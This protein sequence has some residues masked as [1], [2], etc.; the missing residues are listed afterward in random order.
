MKL[1]VEN[2]VTVSKKKW[3][4]LDPLLVLTLQGYQ[5]AGLYHDLRSLCKKY[6]EEDILPEDVR[7]GDLWI[8]VKTDQV[9][10]GELAFSYAYP[11]DKVVW[12]IINNSLYQF[13]PDRHLSEEQKIAWYKQVEAGTDANNIGS[14]PSN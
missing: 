10:E 9:G 8:S 6:S 2:E 3:G 7:E 12:E 1:G 11:S 5:V 14:F 4:R 13:D